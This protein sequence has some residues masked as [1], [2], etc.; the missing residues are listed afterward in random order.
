MIKILVVDDNTKRS[1]EISELLYSKYSLTSDSI[2]CVDNVDSA[3]EALRNSYF[4]VLL[5]DVILPRKSDRSRASAENG[6]SLLEEVSRRKIY[7]TP[8]KII[9][10]TASVDDIFSFRTRFE[11]HCVV[12]VEASND[13]LKWKGH[14]IDAIGSTISSKMSRVPKDKSV[15]VIT[16][17]GIRTFGDWQERLKKIVCS[18]NDRFEFC[19]YE[20]GYFS[21]IA[22]FIPLLRHFVVK[23]FESQ[24]RQ[25]I[26][27]TPD[28]AIYIFSHSFGTYITTK[29]ID[30]ILKDGDDINLELL[31]LSGSV[32]KSSFDWNRIIKRTKACIV[33]DC[34]CNDLVL[35][36]S[37]ALVPNTGMAGKLGFYGINTE[38]FTNRYFK[39]GHSHYFNT[40]IFMEKYWLPLFYNINEIEKVDHRIPSPIHHGIFDKVI[41]FIGNLKPL[42]YI[43]LVIIFFYFTINLI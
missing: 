12:V 34:G 17:H 39:G 2:V 15:L 1:T 20:Y 14:I 9:G 36:L 11:K 33:N 28:K 30:R 18:K 41:L 19:P 26:A 31:V 43:A 5:L 27:H 3:K 10:I 8:E 7:R 40:D 13:N 35:W 21:V 22:F 42:I 24:L 25:L 32:L 29:A 16:V 38:R 37:E 4:D 6:I 23:N